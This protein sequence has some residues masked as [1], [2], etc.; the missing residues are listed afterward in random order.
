MTCPLSLFWGSCFLGHT[1]RP[2]SRRPASHVSTGRLCPPGLLKWAICGTQLQHE[3][4]LPS[5][6]PP[7]LYYHRLILA[8]VFTKL[9]LLNICLNLQVVSNQE[10]T[11]LC[12]TATA[13]SSVITTS[14]NFVLIT[15]RLRVACY[16]M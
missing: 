2:V 11:E 4:I 7:S 12:M 16:D 14:I 13:L 3:S 6:T 5:S 10:T 8:E 9:A 15:L 1:G